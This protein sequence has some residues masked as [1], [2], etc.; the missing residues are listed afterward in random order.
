MDER[1]NA[2]PLR[3]VPVESSLAAQV[4]PLLRTMRP[5]QW[6]KNLLVYLAFFF[7]AGEHGSKSLTT[8]F[9]LFG[10]ATLAFALFC[11]L[12]GAT[13]IFNDLVDVQADRLHPAKRARPLASGRVHHVGDVVPDVPQGLALQHVARR[14]LEEVF[15]PEAPRLRA[16]DAPL[17]LQAA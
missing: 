8:E 12:S 17:G 10:D 7:T 11:L 14:L 9:H 13:Y 1:L 4:W 16:V 6:A 3:T 15:D 5:R 2:S